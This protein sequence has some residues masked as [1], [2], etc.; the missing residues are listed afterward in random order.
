MDGNDDCVTLVVKLKCC[1]AAGI[2]SNWSS[3]R[4]HC[5]NLG[6]GHSHELVNA[7]LSIAVRARM[8]NFIAGSDAKW[9]QAT[10]EPA[11][12]NRDS[13]AEKPGQRTDRL[14]TFG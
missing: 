13:N 10:A 12:E 14:R 2:V 6:W 4:A 3:G 5:V 9:N 8:S 7:E 1:T 11:T